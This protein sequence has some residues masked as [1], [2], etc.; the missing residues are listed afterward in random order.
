MKELFRFNDVPVTTET[1]KEE[2]WLKFLFL[3][4]EKNVNPEKYSSVEDINFNPT[5]EYVEKTLRVFHAVKHLDKTLTDN[6]AEMCVLRTLQWNEV[7]KCGTEKDRK[8]WEEKGYPLGIHNEASAKIYFEES[9]D[10]VWMTRV[11][12]ALI[13][14]HGSIGQFIRGEVSYSEF[15]P[16]LNLLTDKIVSPE[17]LKAMLRVLNEA[18][19]AS[20]SSELWD[21]V[22]S[23]VYLVIDKICSKQFMSWKTTERLKKLFPTAFAEEK[24]LTNKEKK[25]IHNIFSYVSLWYPEIALDTFSRDEIFIILSM[26]EQN[27]SKN[28]RHVSFYPLANNLF[29]DYEGKKKVNIYKKRIIEFCLKEY[30]EEIED[31]KANEHVNFVSEVKGD[32]LYFDVKF[33]KACES[34]INFCVEAERSG[35]MDYQKNITTIFDMFGFRRDIFDRLNNEDKYLTTMNSVNTSRKSEILDYVVGDKIVDV[36]S[37]GGVLLDLLEEKYPEKTIIGTDISQNVIE[38]LNK[39]ILEEKHHYTVMN[40]NFVEAPLAEKVDTI[41]FSSILHEV[42]SYTNFE[43]CKFNIKS[44]KKALVNAESSLNPGGR[45][46]IRDGILSEENEGETYTVVFKTPQTYNF[47][48]NYIR[49]FKGLKNQR[50]ENGYW[51]SFITDFFNDKVCLSGNINLIRE[52]LYTLTWGEESYSCEVNEQFGYFT[53]SEYAGYL[54]YIGLKV[55]KKEAYLEQGYVDHLKDSVELVNDLTWEK[56][57]SNAILV[58]EK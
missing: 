28:I 30:E 26:I 49:D 1:L 35:I 21:S 37:G 27:I 47:F 56:I 33:T 53:L 5:L 50:N 11:V 58:A 40:H 18:V 24:E 13:Q 38:T 20:V 46:V 42:F 15:T 29:Y 16:L 25:L 4:D 54:E 48:N 43:G 17:E 6:K 12:Y 14:T 45:I 8:I 57:P 32:T 55:I 10:S 31:V 41:I 22:K 36:G 2:K 51:K 7:S 3:T 19:I 44:V 34:L 39:K 9:T 23:Q 52:F